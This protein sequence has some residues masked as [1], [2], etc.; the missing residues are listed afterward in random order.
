MRILFALAAIAALPAMAGCNSGGVDTAALEEKHGNRRDVT[1]DWLAGRWSEDRDC[2]Q[3][4]EFVS[5]GDYREDRGGNERWRLDEGRNSDEML[6][7]IGRDEFRA[8][9][10]GSTLVLI[11]DQD[12]VIE[13]ERCETGSTTANAGGT[14]PGVAPAAP[15][16]PATPAN[17]QLEQGIAA[18][19]QMLRAQLPMR[20]GPLTITS[21]SSSGT[22]LTLV[23]T[24]AIDVTEA[25]WPQFEQG[26]RQG[27]CSGSSAQMIQMGASVVTQ[28]TDA[29]GETRSF[30]VDRCP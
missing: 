18:G 14:A 5:G 16:T 7:E 20:Q 30:T 26:L 9:R 10:Y 22:Q 17:P 12:R 24:L 13:L 21:V 11:D 29:A 19:V 1:N 8:Q 25:Q 3:F 27:N 2:R 15:A 4:R 6:L 28:I 23:G